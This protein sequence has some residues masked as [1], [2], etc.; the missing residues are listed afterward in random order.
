MIDPAESMYESVTLND[1]YL[2]KVYF[3]ILV[4]CVAK[5]S[6][7]TYRRLVEQAKQLHPQSNHVKGAI[8]VS[9]GRKLEVIFIFTKQRK[10]PDITCLVINQATGTV[11]ARC[12]TD[13]KIEREKVMNFDWSAVFADFDA[14][15]NDAMSQAGAR[16]ER[17]A[18]A[19]NLMYAYYNQ[20]RASLPKNI[21]NQRDF[22]LKLLM[23]GVDP[24]TAFSRAVTSAKA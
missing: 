15:I 5:R 11:G 3:P 8:P 17:L 9:T 19:A 12:V 6:D 24:E 20:H 2:A 18:A 22:V 16:E 23:D 4:E 10:L 21:T 13:P 14:F 7:V 1:V